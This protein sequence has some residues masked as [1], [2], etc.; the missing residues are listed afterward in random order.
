MVNGKPA[1]AWIMERQCVKTHKAIGIVNNANRYALGTT[2]AP[3][4][5]LKLLARVIC[6][7][8]ETQRV[9]DQLPEPAWD[10]ESRPICA[11]P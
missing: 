7:S 6:V 11:A 2:H 5:P 10:T 9:V 1:I 3:A 4:Y 8:M